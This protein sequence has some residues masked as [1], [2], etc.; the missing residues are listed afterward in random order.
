MFF[1]KR[2]DCIKSILGFK[3]RLQIRLISI[4]LGLM[5]S[6]YLAAQPPSSSAVVHRRTLLGP[7]IEGLKWNADRLAIA[8]Q[9]VKNQDRTYVLL[10]GEFHRP[11]FDLYAHQ[12]LVPV[13]S[14]GRFQLKVS[15][16]SR[17]IQVSLRATNHRGV[18]ETEEV[19]L[20]RYLDKE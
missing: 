10:E 8:S 3:P 2:S 11:E 12:R 9:K 18:V 7:K 15:F 5:F 20:L 6:P 16:R 4:F 13:D 1:E 19:L 17:P 14:E